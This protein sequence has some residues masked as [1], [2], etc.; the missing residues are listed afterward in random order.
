M[1]FPPVFRRGR[2][3]MTSLSKDKKIYTLTNH[4]NGFSMRLNEFTEIFF[5]LSLYIF[6]FVQGFV[7]IVNFTRS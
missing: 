4:P 6:L 7:Y 5:S 2:H 3:F 1:F